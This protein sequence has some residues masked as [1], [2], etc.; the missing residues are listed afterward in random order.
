MREIFYDV[1]QRPVVSG[2]QEYAIIRIESLQLVYRLLGGLQINRWTSFANPDKRRMRSVSPVRVA[3]ADQRAWAGTWREA[4]HNYRI[5]KRHA[6][7]RAQC[8]D[9]MVRIASHEQER[10]GVGC[11]ASQRIDV[12]DGM[13]WRREEVQRPVAYASLVPFRK[14]ESRCS[15]HRKSRAP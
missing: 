10:V 14:S 4:W 7:T 1:L 13:A 12:S 3:G 9:M 15:T 11:G 6:I 5:R 2:D 8:R